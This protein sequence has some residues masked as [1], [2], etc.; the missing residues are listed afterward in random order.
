MTFVQLK[1]RNNGLALASFTLSSLVGILGT[2]A[3]W[4]VIIFGVNTYRPAVKFKV[5]IPGGICESLISARG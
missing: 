5:A 3:N 1:L 2:S 4:V